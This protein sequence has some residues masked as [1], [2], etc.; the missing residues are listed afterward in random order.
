[1]TAYES[2]RMTWPPIVSVRRSRSR[3]PS[4]AAAERVGAPSGADV[5]AVVGAPEARAPDEAAGR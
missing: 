5:P 1:M 2:T 4:V 3:K